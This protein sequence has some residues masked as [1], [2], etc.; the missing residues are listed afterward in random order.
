MNP[1]VLAFTILLLASAAA[2]CGPSPG[3]PAPP[4]IAYGLDVCEAC[5]MIVSD[6]RFAAA[7]ALEDGSALKFDDIGDMMRYHASRPN[8]RVQAWFV[9]DHPSEAW[10]EAQNAAFALSPGIASP[11]GH[12]LA[13]F[14][15]PAAAA[16]YATDIGGEVLTFNEL[17]SRYAAP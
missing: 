13:A 10:L 12:G 11:M 15:D 16:D 7:T 9:H 4:E 3:A 17:R 6:A 5:G 14:A 8:L 2:G 1:R